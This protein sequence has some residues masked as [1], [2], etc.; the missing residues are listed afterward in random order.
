MTKRR[1][2]YHLAGYGPIGANWHRLFNRELTTFTRTWNVSAQASAAS[3]Q[4]AASSTHWRVTTSA[5]NWRVETE[6]AMLVWDDI[7]L[8]D[9]ARPITAR[10][11]RSALAF[12]DIMLTGTAARY[13]KATWQYGLFFLFPFVLLL[14]FG[15]VAVAI[16][17]YLATA[18]TSSPAL[19]AVYLVAL[20][21]AIFIALLFWPGQRWGVQHGLDDWIFSWDYLY[22]RRPDMEARLDRFA[23]ALV[24]RSHDATLDEIVIVGH[25]MG[26][27]LAVEV[28]ARALAID[29]DLGRHGPVVCL[30]TV[31]STIPK[32]TLHPAGER[33][34]RHAEQIVAEPSIAW[35]EYQAR[36]DLVSF[37]KLDPVRLTRFPGDPRRGKPLMRRVWLHEMLTPRT[38]WRIRLRFMRLH[39][40]FVMA[41]E[42]RSTYDF[43]ML[44]CGPIPFARFTLAPTGAA[45]LIASDGTL[46]DQ[47]VSLGPPP[48]PP[49][50]SASQDARERAYAGE[51]QGEGCGGA[52]AG[53]PSLQPA[54]KERSPPIGRR[55][56]LSV[57]RRMIADL[58]WA[59]SD[60]GRVSVTRPVAF[61]DLMTAREELAAA[62]SWTAIF[63]KGFALVAAEIP[64]LRRVYV[65]LPWPHLY[66]YVDSTVCIGH[67]R[68]I[69]G[70]LGVLPL[71]FHQPNTVPIGQLSEMIRRA[72]AAPLEETRLHRK[73]V[74]IARLP[75]LLRRLI[76][77]VWLNVPRL[78]R[79]LGTYGVSS[80]ARWRTDLGTSRTPQ[81]CLLSYG[82]ADADGNVVARLT[83]DHRVFDGALA[84]RALARLDE[85]LN[86]SILEELRDLAKAEPRALLQGGGQVS[87]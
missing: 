36:S 6:Y 83:F 52:N 48:Y 14:V 15:F 23:E 33:F 28:V 69:M 29:P 11:A 39:H 16:A 60:T 49:P 72:A 78:R 4:P 2:V 51:G 13:F 22:G 24:A 31:G 45:G 73:L 62:P 34:R 67:E 42:R 58:M 77:F 80:A 1:C 50:H 7:I 46:V 47:P 21:A 75:L 84:G 53:G 55:I 63:V 17:H 38:Y 56:R 79:E 74:A 66:E 68:W 43:F 85:I 70:D 35:T 40:Q 59:V 44:V 86:S 10:L 76:I 64:E 12:L 65:K 71:R 27:T 61:R 54:G 20:S 3:P 9:F 18:L 81:P 82:P 41:N 87:G 32:F 19:A 8:S 37:Y 57:A 25:S 26:A 30:L 5:P